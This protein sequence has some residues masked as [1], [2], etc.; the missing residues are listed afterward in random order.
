MRCRGVR[1]DQ[2]GALDDVD[3]GPAQKETGASAVLLEDFK[4]FLALKATHKDW[5]RT[6]LP[7]CFEP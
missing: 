5:A 2:P 7:Q 1:G 3:F 6:S 4:R